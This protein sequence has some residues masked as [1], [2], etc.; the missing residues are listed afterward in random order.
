MLGIVAHGENAAV[1]VGIERLDPAVHDLREARDITD[2]EHGDARIADRLH[3]AAR[4]DDLNTGIMQLACELDDAR[5]VRY[6]D[7]ST[8]DFHGQPPP[9]VY[10]KQIA[11]SKIVTW[12][13]STLSRPST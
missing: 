4:R 10:N 6:T 8:L 2:V 13:P 9:F 12:R 7:E 11:Y 1:D 3:R 5:L